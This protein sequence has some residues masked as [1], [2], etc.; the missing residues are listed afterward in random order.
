MSKMKRGE[1]RRDAEDKRRWRW[2][3]SL[4]KRWDERD[5]DHDQEGLEEVDDT[6]MLIVSFKEKKMVWNK[7]KQRL[8]KKRKGVSDKKKKI[9]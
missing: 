9:E 5:N 1:N 8:K 3:W 2:C 6:V 7:K 4:E